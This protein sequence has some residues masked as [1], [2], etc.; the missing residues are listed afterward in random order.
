MGKENSLQGNEGEVRLSYQEKHLLERGGKE[1]RLL[2][3]SLKVFVVS[4]KHPQRKRI[5]GYAGCG[6]RGGL[7][8]SSDSKSLGRKIQTSIWRSGP[9]TP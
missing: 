5:R 3:N 8:T 1:A 2:E 9:R 7:K 4:G 6:E